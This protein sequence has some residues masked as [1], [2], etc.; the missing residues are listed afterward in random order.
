MSKAIIAVLN[1]KDLLNYI[2]C[3][4]P[5]YKN[6]YIVCIKK[7]IEISIKNIY[8]KICK[9]LIEKYIQPEFI[10]DSYIFDRILWMHDG[11]YNHEQWY[12]KNNINCVNCE[13]IFSKLSSYPR[14]QE[15]YIE[16]IFNDV[17][18]DPEKNIYTCNDYN[19]VPIITEDT[20]N[21]EFSEFILDYDY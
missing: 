9:K 18:Y 16:I 2:H 17:Y 13:C 15:K 11:Y 1:N 14:N 21:N 19:W 12:G 5:T 3:F 10:L 20:Y 8:I 7:V 4:D 6:L